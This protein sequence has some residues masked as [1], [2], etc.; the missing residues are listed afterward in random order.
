[1]KANEALIFCALFSMQQ[2]HNAAIHITEFRLTL[3]L[4]TSQISTLLGLQDSVE[5]WRGL[6]DEYEVKNDK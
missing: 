2:K 1:M 6:H 4:A 3:R 5:A